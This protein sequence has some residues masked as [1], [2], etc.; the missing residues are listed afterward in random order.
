MKNKNLIIISILIICLVITGIFAY[1]KIS[2]KNNKNTPDIDD[3][4]GIGFDETSPDAWEMNLYIYGFNESFKF[5]PED[6]KFDFKGE[7]R[8]T[9]TLTDLEALGMDISKFNTDSIHCDKEKTYLLFEYDESYKTPNKVV[10]EFY[11]EC[12][13]DQ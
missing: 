2:D 3:N 6:Y 7:K 4:R 5:F 12:Q 10:R 9:Y 1:T 13:K 8:I 11:L